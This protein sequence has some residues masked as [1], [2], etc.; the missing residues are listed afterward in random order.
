MA[1]QPSLCSRQPSG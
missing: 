1:S